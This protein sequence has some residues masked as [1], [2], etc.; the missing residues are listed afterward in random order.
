M[1][2]YMVKR[3]IRAPFPCIATVI[4]TFA[5]TLMLGRLT[6]TI[7]EQNRQLEAI[8]DNMRI[9]CVFADP[10]GKTDDILIINTLIDVCT[11]NKYKLSQFI[12]DPLFKRSLNYR[13]ETKNS[14]LIGV[15]SN[16]LDDRLKDLPNNVFQSC[17]YVIFVNE[18]SDFVVGDV[19]DL[20]V[21]LNETYEEV[22]FTVAGTYPGEKSDIIYCPWKVICELAIDLGG[23]I[24]AE[25]GSFILAD[26]HRL[27]EFKTEAN[28]YFAKVDISG[29]GFTNTISYIAL[30]IH[31]NKFQT[32]T[33]AVMHNIKMLYIL[34]PIFYILTLGIGFLVGFLLIRNRYKEFDLLRRVGVKSKII[35]GTVLIEQSVSAL[36]GVGLGMIL[37]KK[38]TGVLLF[39]LYI[40]GA[41]ISLLLLFSK[42]IMGTRSE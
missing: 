41:F 30:L 31:D 23:Q 13:T 21:R 34:F 36:F 11:S 38:I 40:L 25:S 28:E 33:S 10:N 8:Y 18:H 26:N 3:M 32:T 9:N 16:S 6:V 12:S 24:S 5:F 2:I 42:S 7:S 27:N 4:I 22:G 14:L 20:I 37:T 29:D 17:D 15:N 1:L 19:V 39:M 35:I